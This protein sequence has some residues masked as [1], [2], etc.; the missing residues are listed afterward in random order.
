M[1]RVR[2]VVQENS[3]LDGSASSVL[4]KHILQA[5]DTIPEKVR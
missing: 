2:D 1:K 3:K 5:L 4:A